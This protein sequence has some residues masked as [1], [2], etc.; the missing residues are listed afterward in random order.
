MKLP[1]VFAPAFLAGFAGL[2]TTPFAHAGGIDWA[3]V[4]GK[5]IVLFAPGQTPW[6]WVLT[7][8]EMS[9]AQKFREE[10]K[11]CTDC[12]DG[13]EA[14]MGAD[15]VANKTRMFTPSRSPAYEK[16]SREPNPI[17]G[18]PGSITATV[19]FAHDADTLYV[20]LDVKDGNQPNA[21]Q[22][23]E[24][25][26]KVTV[27]FTAAKTPDVTRGGCASA[28]HDDMTGMPSAGDA[29][30]THYLAGTH[31]KITRQGGGDT[32]KPDADL[33]KLKGDGYYL[34]DWQAKVNP[35]Q[36]ARAAAYVVFAKRDTVALPLT[37]EASVSAGVTSVTLSGKLSPGGDYLGFSPGTIYHVSFAVH[38]GHTA[39][40]YH[41][42]TLE[43]SLML[44]SGSADFVVLK[45]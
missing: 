43:K 37:A 23:A 21:G 2:A 16:P 27:R 5:E 15:L 26:T 22:D 4:P 30:R 45:K 41:Y 20:H 35:G 34:E 8:A 17:A 32:L 31:A 14:T 11:A 29:T 33:A 13:D 25:A 40:R 19:K 44:D 3:S 24:N 7:Q 42:I 12:H 38:D 10:G 1:A 18:K 6:E 36:P 28:C 9:G 39:G